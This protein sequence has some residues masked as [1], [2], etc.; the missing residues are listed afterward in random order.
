MGIAGGSGTLF[1][2]ENALSQGEKGYCLLGKKTAETLF[3]STNIVGRSIVIGEKTYEVAGVEYREEELC[4]Y[5]LDPG[6]AG[7]LDHAAYAFQDKKQKA[8]TEQQIINIFGVS[9]SETDIF[10]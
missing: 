6:D 10:K 3:G 7:S 8:M 5:E 4:L 1:P 2:G 9:G